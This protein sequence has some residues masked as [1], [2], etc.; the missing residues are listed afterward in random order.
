M[1]LSSVKEVRVKRFDDEANDLLRQGW[2]L[3][4]IETG[5]RRVHHV[6]PKNGVKEPEGA[7]E[8]PYDF[9]VPFCLFVLGRAEE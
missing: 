2:I 1:E 9:D 7:V 4:K 3:L 6:P 5:V 8:Q